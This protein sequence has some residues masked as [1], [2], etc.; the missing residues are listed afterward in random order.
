MPAGMSGIDLAHAATRLRPGLKVS[1]TS[2][3]ADAVREALSG[4]AEFPFLAKP[5][6]A[7]V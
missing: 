5:Y 3:Y 6:R 4:G 1:L 7:P 2:G